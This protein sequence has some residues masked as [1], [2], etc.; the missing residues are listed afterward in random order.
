M[1]IKFFAKLFAML[2]VLCCGCPETTAKVYHVNGQITFDGRP[3][4]KGRIDF[5]GQVGKA[6]N[7]SAEIIN[8]KFDT[9]NVGSSGIS[10]GK[11]AL[12]ILGFDGKTGNELPLGN[13]LFLEYTMTKEFPE[14]DS[15]F[16]V[17]VP[18]K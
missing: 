18:K 7:G 14:S 3:I 16:S 4:P 17:D 9:R 15:E 11:Y 5:D 13:P 12:R 6:K 10:G 2:M 8:G 1:R